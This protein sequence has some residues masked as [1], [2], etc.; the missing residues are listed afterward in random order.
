MTNSISVIVM[1]TFLTCNTEKPK[2]IESAA[3]LIIS[4]MSEKDRKII[5]ETSPDQLIMYHHG[6][7]TGIRNDLGL[8]GGNKELLEDCGN[9]HPDNCS[10]L[11]EMIQLKRQNRVSQLC[12]RTRLLRKSNKWE[13]IQIAV[14]HK[15]NKESPPLRT[16]ETQP[17][18]V[19]KL[20]CPIQ[21]LFLIVNGMRSILI[22]IVAVVKNFYCFS[23]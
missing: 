21:E 1:A 3:K 7:G 4:E 22:K 12:H 19:N 13:C 23:R 10:I 17:I 8:W 16:A 18:T 15:T 5:K 6:W 20:T 11:E 14:N 9:T 2:T